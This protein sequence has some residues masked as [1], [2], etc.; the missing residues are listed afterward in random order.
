MFWKLAR[1]PVV[2]GTPIVA[3]IQMKDFINLLSVQTNQQ[4]VIF[5]AAYARSLVP[6]ARLVHK[7]LSTTE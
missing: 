5:T 1:E 7:Q 4:N 2:T 6:C 3:L